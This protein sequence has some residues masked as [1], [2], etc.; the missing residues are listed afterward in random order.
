MGLPPKTSGDLQRIDL[1]VLPPGHLIAGLM[2]LS[3]MATT[4]RHGELVADL[5]TARAQLGEPQMMR[6]GRLPP[7]DHAGL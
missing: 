2:Q 1:Q 4:E 3:M 6:I 7:A 5:E